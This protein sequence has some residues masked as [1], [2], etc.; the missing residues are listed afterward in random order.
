MP[1]DNKN[2]TI[3]LLKDKDI[4]DIKVTYIEIVDIYGTTDYNQL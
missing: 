1:V 3:D 2:L 4:L